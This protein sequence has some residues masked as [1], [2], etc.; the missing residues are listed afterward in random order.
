[1]NCLRAL[2]DAFAAPIVSPVPPPGGLTRLF[3]ARRESD[4]LWYVINPDGQ[5]TGGPYDVLRATAI[6]H[7]ANLDAKAAA[8]AA[9]RER[10]MARHVAG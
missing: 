10:E 3:T 1:M 6:A 8:N 7:Q 2:R 5:I 4:G 9:I